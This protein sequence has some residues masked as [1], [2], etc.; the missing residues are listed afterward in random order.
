MKY[1]LKR[2]G[3]QELGSMDASMRPS[4]GQYLLIPMRGEASSL[5]PPLSQTQLNDF[6]LVAIYP[7]FTQEKVYCRYVY[8]NDRFH[9]S[10]AEFPRNEYRLY[11]NKELQGGNFKFFENGI[12]VLRNVREN[13]FDSGLYLDYADPNDDKYS[14]YERILNE[15][16][17]RTT[18]NFAVY[19]GR[20]NEFEKS[21][22]EIDI[23]NSRIEVAEEDIRYIARREGEIASLF[24]IPQ[25]RDFVSFAYQR[26]CAVTRTV[27]EYG[28]LNNLETAHI[29]PAAHNGPPLPSNGISLC[30]DF[31]WAFDHGF[32]TLTDDY[33][34]IISKQA[35]SEMLIPYDGKPIFLPEE[36]FF[37]PKLEFIQYHRQNIFEHFG[38]IRSI[39]T[40]G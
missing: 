6:H 19:D 15:H 25:F 23:S 12:V 35:P 31:H 7:L 4:R 13:D 2:C 1:F 40:R 28:E 8:H 10:L 26:K 24:T 18:D 17:L 39:S 32:W 33:K 5:F 30:R 9:G 20:I 34:V 29:M 27:I 22:D 14:V 38:Q 21:V 16:K 37:R 11:L 36:P 3:H